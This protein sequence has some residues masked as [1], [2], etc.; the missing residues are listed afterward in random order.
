MPSRL[1]HFPRPPTATGQESTRQYAETVLT[2]RTIP[3]RHDLAIISATG[4]IDTGSV[5]LLQRALWQDLP[6]GLVLDLSRVTFLGAAGL[7]AI[8]GVVTRARAERRRI[9]IVA[10]ARPVLRPL[11][12]FGVD[13]LVV[14]YPILADALREVPLSPPPVAGATDWN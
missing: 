9:G 12:I 7:R 1:S 4:E 8:E 3:W 5:R 2:V 14:V 11:R 13:T 10:A 6:A